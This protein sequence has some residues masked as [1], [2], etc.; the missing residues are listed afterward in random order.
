MT[1]SIVLASAMI[2][3]WEGFRAQAYRCPAGVL[4]IGYG[5]TRGVTE[6]QTTTEAAERKW[7][8]EE[9]EKM[10]TV[11]RRA[12]KV[13]LA[14]EHEAALL[15][16]AYN[17]GLDA[18]LNSTLMRKL[19][20]GQ[21]GAV[22]EELMRWN[23]ARDPKTG[24]LRQL[25]GL[26]RRRADEAALWASAGGTDPTPG[27]AAEAPRP[28]PPVASPSLWGLIIAAVPQIWAQVE[29]LRDALA[30]LVGADE[31]AMILGLLTLTGVALIGWRWWTARRNGL[32]STERVE[33]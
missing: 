28:K 25:S 32:I 29:P 8:R 30:S 22:P 1:D 23:K 24:K 10:R 21:Y 20:R 9:L 16:W 26:A 7:L 19:S 6:G 5:R 13:T 27:I 15:S 33:L 2:A 11:I 3:R 17:V 4:T 12:A 31:A 18:A 14:P